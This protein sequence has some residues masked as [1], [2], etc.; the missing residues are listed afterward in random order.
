MNDVTR[1]IQFIANSLKIYDKHIEMFFKRFSFC[2]SFRQIVT[3]IH[4]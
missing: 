4:Q 2:C 3:S 1:S